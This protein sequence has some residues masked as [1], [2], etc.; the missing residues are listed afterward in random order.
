MQSNHN[1]KTFDTKFMTDVAFDNFIYYLVILSEILLMKSR[2]KIRTLLRNAGR[3]L[4]NFKQCA[5]RP[6]DFWP[7]Y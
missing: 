4:G 1:M 2:Q 6:L 3:Q 7:I 5:R